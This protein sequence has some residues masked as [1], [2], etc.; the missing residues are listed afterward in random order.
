M[1]VLEGI[2]TLVL[3]AALSPQVRAQFLVP[4]TTALRSVMEDPSIQ[5]NMYDFGGNPAWLHLDRNTHGLAVYGTRE[6][7]AGSYHRPFDP[8]YTT[9]YQYFLE[10]TKQVTDDQTFR[11]QFG[12]RQDF[13]GDWMWVDAKNSSLRSPFLIADSSSGMTAYRGIVMDAQYSQTIG[14]SLLVGVQLDYAVDK[15]LK[16]ASPKPTSMNRDLAFAAGSAYRV[17]DGVDAGASFRYLDQQEEITFEADPS[18]LLRET[19]LYKFRGFDRYIRISKKDE[20]RKIQSRGYTGRVHLSLRPGAETMIL[21]Y[22]GGGVLNLDVKDGGTSPSNQGFYQS[23]L[24]ETRIKAKH[25]TRGVVLG[26][27]GGFEWISDWARHP[28]FNVLLMKGSSALCKAALGVEIPEITPYL[29]LAAEYAFTGD[30]EITHDYLS[31]MDVDITRTGHDLSIGSRWK[32]SE[33]VRAGVFYTFSLHRP[34]RTSVS[35]VDPSPFYLQTRSREFDFLSAR[36]LG[37]S[38]TLQCEYDSGPLGTVILAARYGMLDVTRSTVF[39]SANRSLVN[40]SLS[41]RFESI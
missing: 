37:N 41:F 25:E 12:F 28:D 39:G 4:P 21:L 1:K 13:R 18:A 10:G 22:G 6:A 29:S 34:G 20:F 7:E 31:G 16:E 5:M 26:L 30:Q 40:I 27:T 24:V 3:A 33:R 2:A 15:G 17:S 36:A 38:A 32:L 19:I 8:G 35:V 23:D 11:G 14:G 9:S